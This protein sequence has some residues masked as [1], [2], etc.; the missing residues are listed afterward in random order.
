MKKWITGREQEIE[1][2]GNKSHEL[3][4]DKRV[5]SGNVSGWKIG[6]KEQEDETSEGENRKWEKDK[7][8]EVKVSK[9]EQ[10]KRRKEE[11]W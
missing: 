10:N 2:K 1:K 3:K 6:R 9:P 4:N 8:R 5:K 7:E 11:I